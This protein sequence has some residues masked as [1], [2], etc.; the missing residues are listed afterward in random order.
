VPYTVAPKARSRK[1]EQ[2]SN[3]AKR[4][5]SIFERKFESMGKP[6]K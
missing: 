6:L 3:I 1:N 5:E 2:R 4:L